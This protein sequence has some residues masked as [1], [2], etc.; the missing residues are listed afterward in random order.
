MNLM[1]TQM[2]EGFESGA[3]AALAETEPDVRMREGM[4]LYARAYA[5]HFSDEPLNLAPLGS[6]LNPE[7]GIDY[8]ETEA[9]R[10]L[11]EPLTER[12]REMFDQPEDLVLEANLRGGAMEEVGFDFGGSQQVVIDNA[13]AEAL[14]GSRFLEADIVAIY[15]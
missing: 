13:V 10:R 15:W 7:P 11:L 12:L 1:S 8:E 6:L 2:I 4:E 3:A 9:R 5:A 14:P